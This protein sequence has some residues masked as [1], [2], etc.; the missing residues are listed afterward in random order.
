[1]AAEFAPHHAGNTSTHAVAAGE[2]AR[3]ELRGV[4]E[5]ITYQNPDNGYTVARLASEGRDAGPAQGTADERLVTLAGTLP[6][7]R[8]R[9]QSTGG[10][11]SVNQPRRLTSRE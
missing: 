10:T 4:V 7:L 6:E 5:R 2:P 3:R 1:M 9:T 11:A 8:Y